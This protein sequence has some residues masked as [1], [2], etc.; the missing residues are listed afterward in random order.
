MLTYV[1]YPTYWQNLV[2]DSWIHSRIEQGFLFS[3]KTHKSCRFCRIVETASRQKSFMQLQDVAGS[4]QVISILQE[5]LGMYLLLQLV[6]LQISINQMIY[7]I[8]KCIQLNNQ[9]DQKAVI[10]V[11]QQLS[12]TCV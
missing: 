6:Y 7:V 12:H 5:S 4:Q 8:N 2:K 11:V 9:L 1:T 3:R 10:Q